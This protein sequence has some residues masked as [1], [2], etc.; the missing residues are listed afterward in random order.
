MT[1]WPTVF[2]S[3][4]CA[5]PSAPGGDRDRDHARDQR[6]EQL[7][8]VL[9]DRVVEHGSQQE[10]RDHAERRRD[11]DQDEH[12]GEPSPVGPEQREQPA[13]IDRSPVGRLRTRGPL[14]LPQHRDPGPQA[15]PTSRSSMPRSCSRSAVG[16]GGEQVVLGGLGR[17]PRAQQPAPAGGGQLHEMAAPVVRVARPHEQAVGLEQVEQAD[18]VARVDPQRPPELLLGERAGLGKMVEDGELVRPHLHRRQRLA[19]P[20]ARHAGQPHDQQDQ[21]GARSAGRAVVERVLVFITSYVSG[22]SC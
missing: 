18:E 15:C 13:A 20:V 8:V 11:Q 5:T 21:P 22:K 2:E 1:R 16:K 6:R 9:G 14:G 10:R 7:G 12:G 3:S 4:V 17:L 19:Q